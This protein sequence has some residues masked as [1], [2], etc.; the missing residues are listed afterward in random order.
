MSIELRA[1]AEDEHPAFQ[2][3]ES[4]G[5]GA[6]P[7]GPE[8]LAEDRSVFEY[9]RTIC[10]FDGDQ[11]VATTTAYTFGLTVP[12]GETITAA[13]VSSVAVLA[14]HRRQGILRRIMTKQ[15]DDV[16]GRGEPVAVLN[17]SES[18][19]YSRFGYGLASFF[20]SWE[21]DTKRAF[22]RDHHEDGFALRLVPK[23]D[24]KK[25]LMALYDSWRVE[26]PGALSQS[27][28]W[29]DCALSD[30]VDWRGGGPL[31]VVICEPDAGGA[32]RG[33]FATYEIDQS[34]H[35][36]HWRLE[37]RD[38]VAADHAV[39]AH[40]WRYL[41]SVDLIGTVAAV[42]RPLDDPLRW[43]LTDP[44][45]VRTTELR[46]FLYVR[47]LDVET[48]LASRRYPVAD[49]LVLDVHDELRPATSGRYRITGRPDAANC[50]RTDADADLV[51]GI[52]ELGSISL[53]G[54]TPR[55]LARVGRIRERTPGAVERATAMFGWP[56]APF[57][58]TRF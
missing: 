14:T 41:L 35:I 37:V 24:A 44:R 12:G 55:E 6:L 34:A 11:M 13:G 19:I 4:T 8:Q 17:A 25:D 54:V 39:E 26:R 3:V 23:Q 42:A 21:I 33:G 40:L 28:A 16:A 31:F 7:S 2:L 45:Q 50:E 43:H 46:D 53:G 38:L 29:W 48:T 10:A 56:L 20:Q 52:S 5:F 51:L 47:I 1:I 32:H 36:G 27:E 9:D 58:I 22:F 30:H 15:L 49:D 18:S 57:C